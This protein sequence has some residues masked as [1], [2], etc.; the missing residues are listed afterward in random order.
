V[1]RWL[2]AVLAGCGCL[3]ALLVAVVVAVVAFGS[4]L[5]PSIEGPLVEDFTEEFVEGLPEKLIT[6]EFPEAE[7]FLSPEKADVER[8]TVTIRV[9]GTSGVSFSGNYTEGDISI[10][11]IEGITPQDY[12]AEVR[13]GIDSVAAHV[14]KQGGGNEELTLQ[15]I[16][17][18]EVVKE[19]STSAQSGVVWIALW[20]DEI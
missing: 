2:V 18:G 4:F 16:V 19:E 17:D 9:T 5:L 10:N 3:L 11:S 1:P 14:Q 7:P 6:E 8:K 13:A 20:A 15:G 12:Q